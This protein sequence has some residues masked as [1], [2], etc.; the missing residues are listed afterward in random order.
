M[1]ERDR[2][3]KMVDEGKITRDE[4][5]ELLA[6]LTEID[7]ASVSLERTTR[8]VD[9]EAAAVERTGAPVDAAPAAPPAPPR[10]AVQA[11]DDVAMHGRHAQI[12]ELHE[13]PRDRH[14]GADPADDRHVGDDPDEPEWADDLRHAVDAAGRAAGQAMTDVGR[15]VGEVGRAVF[16]GAGDTWAEPAA[17]KDDEAAATAGFECAPAGTKWLRVNLVVSNLTVKADA[18]VTEP[19]LSGDKDRVKVEPTEY[20][21]LVTRLVPRSDEAGH[22]EWSI[23]F[24]TH[25]PKTELSIRIPTDMGIDTRMTAGELSLVDVPYL[26]GKLTAG[27]VNARNLRGIDFTTA[28]G[29][30]DV[31][32]T[33]RSGRHRVQAS[34]GDVD[35]TLL[36]GSDVAI[37]GTVSIGDASVSGQGLQS[38]RRG[39]GRRVS[40]RLGSGEASL[41]LKVTTGDLSVKARDA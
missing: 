22:G 14:V 1:E 10:P 12:D 25:F 40:G 16:G 13:A 29:D 38:E 32:I 41:D 7:D 33:P 37:T 19:V 5:Q 6:V 28:A 18:S 3:E 20:G 31:E 39:L 8:S 26:R 21:F 24:L 9:R 30:V 34:A 17:S 27:D 2:I 35:V 15:A 11:D 4:A 36:A 23:P